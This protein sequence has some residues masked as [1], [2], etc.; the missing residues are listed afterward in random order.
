MFLSA[1][2]FRLVSAAWT[3]AIRPLISAF[4]ARAHTPFCTAPESDIAGKS[5]C[6][7]AKSRWL[8][9]RPAALP[10]AQ[11]HK[12]TLGKHPRVRSVPPPGRDAGDVV[13]FL[14]N[15]GLVHFAD[16]MT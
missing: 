7:F 3:T 11:N 6:S 8:V 2:S 13:G 4:P 10:I 14:A 1:L 15:I 12:I 5:A 16:A 9:L